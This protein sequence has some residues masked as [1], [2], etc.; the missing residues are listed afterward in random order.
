[1]SPYQTITTIPIT[2]AVDAYTP[3]AKATEKQEKQDQGDE[4]E[5]DFAFGEFKSSHYNIMP[6]P[7]LLISPHT[8]TPTPTPTC[9]HHLL[10]GGIGTVLCFSTNFP[11]LLY[12]HF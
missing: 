5:E 4:E 1:M 6:P 10:G 12:F 7:S 3:M 11:R 8:P 2:T 9:L